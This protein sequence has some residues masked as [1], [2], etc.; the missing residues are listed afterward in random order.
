MNHKIYKRKSDS[1]YFYLYA[2]VCSQSSKDLSFDT[3]NEY[4]P[5][6]TIRLPVRTDYG[7]MPSSSKDN[8]YMNT[9]YCGPKSYPNVRHNSALCCEVCPSCREFPLSFE[10]H[11][12][13]STVGR[14]GGESALM[15]LLDMWVD[16]ET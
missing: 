3:F 13:L 2:F 15:E 9:I 7:I 6:V 1:D 12:L 14:M 8:M 5:A 11:A 4:S 16:H 10:N